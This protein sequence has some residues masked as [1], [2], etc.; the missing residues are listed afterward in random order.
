MLLMHVNLQLDFDTLY[1][2][3]IFMMLLIFSRIVEL[4]MYCELLSSVRHLA[5]KAKI[6]FKSWAIQIILNFLLITSL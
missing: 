6:Y 3:H 1:W 4:R 2:L 5:A